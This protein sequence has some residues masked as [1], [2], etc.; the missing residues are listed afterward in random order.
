MLLNLRLTRTSRAT[1]LR[2]GGL[3]SKLYTSTTTS[4]WISRA[5]LIQWQL[6]SDRCEEFAYVFCRLGRGFEKEKPSLFGICLRISRL[7]RTFVRL[8]SYQIEFVSCQG[9]DDVFVCLS[10]KFFHPLFCLV[11]RRLLTT[12]SAIASPSILGLE[13]YRLRNIVHDNRTV[14]IAVVHRC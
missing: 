6:L 2:S 12:R 10:L 7:D 14:G 5:R 13:T 4:S 11:Q 1:T 3:G 8:F 9:D